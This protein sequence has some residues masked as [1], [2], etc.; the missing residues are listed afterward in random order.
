MNA[1]YFV[2]PFF[3]IYSWVYLIAQSKKPA[4]GLKLLI[5]N[6]D[7]TTLLCILV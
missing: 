1:S 5:F 2:F 7:F 3:N 4:Q 6:G